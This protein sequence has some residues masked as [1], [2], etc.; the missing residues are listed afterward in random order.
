MASRTKARNIPGGFHGSRYPIARVIVAV[1]FLILI[2]VV[3]SMLLRQ[4]ATYQR[5]AER[6]D[7]L[8]Q[9][10]REAVAENDQ[11]NG[12]KSIVGSDEYIEQVARD[13]LGLVKPGETVYKSEG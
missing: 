2:A 1:F 3:G 9:L 4:N 7:E 6:A 12:L 10:E 8:V 11:A 5:V 13:Q